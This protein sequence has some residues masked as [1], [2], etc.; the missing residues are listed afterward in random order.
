MTPCAMGLSPSGVLPGITVSLLGALGKGKYCALV[1]GLCSYGDS[2]AVYEA[3]G[4]R[5]TALSGP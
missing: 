4:L 2:L 3:Y 5:L 1:A